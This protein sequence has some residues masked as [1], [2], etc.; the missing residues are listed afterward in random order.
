MRVLTENDKPMTVIMR[1]R[2]FHRRT[3]PRGTVHRKK[4]LLVSVWLGSVFFFLTANCPTA[5]NSRAGIFIREADAPRHIEELFQGPSNPLVQYSRDVLWVLGT[6][7][8][9]SLLCQKAIIS[10]ILWCYIAEMFYG[11]REVLN[12]SL[13]MPRGGNLS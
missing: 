8:I 9:I 11:F 6:S 7:L 10:Q 5:K 2:I 4:K 12:C 1:V 3:L 13:I